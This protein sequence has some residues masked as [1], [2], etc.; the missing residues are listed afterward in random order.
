MATM[1]FVLSAGSILIVIIIA[2]VAWNAVNYEKEA[3]E[4]RHVI[5]VANSL[6]DAINKVS[7]SQAEDYEITKDLSNFTGFVSIGRGY[8]EVKQGDFSFSRSTFYFNNM[9]LKQ[10]ILE[11]PGIICI[12][13]RE[14]RKC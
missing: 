3:I 11:L 1:D 5:A 4:Q 2:A 13:K 8:V 6:A 14:V 10:S 12:S 9:Q 7:L